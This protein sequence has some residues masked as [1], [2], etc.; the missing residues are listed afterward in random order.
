[1]AAGICFGEYAGAFRNIGNGAAFWGGEMEIS[2]E[3][4][5]NPEAQAAAE[6]APELPVL[7]PFDTQPV[8]A[9]VEMFAQQVRLLLKEAEGI[10]IITDQATA[11]RATELG[12]M[13]KKLSKELVAHK[14]YYEAPHSEYVKKVRNLFKVFLDP[15][16]AI[17]PMLGR[18]LS[19]WRIFQENE[20]RRRIAEQEALARK[21]Q[22]EEEQK[23]RESAEKGAA[24]T[25]VAPAP[26]VVPEVPKTT[27]TTEGSSSQ[28]KEWTFK[29]VDPDKVPN[30][31]R[32]IDEKAIRKA[33]KAGI[34]EI[35][36]VEI[37]QDYI[38]GFRT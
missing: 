30:E 21:I 28:R 32:V 1:M 35:P 20:R 25:P 24:Y 37:F 23:A 18:K 22:K 5:L 11:D 27:R 9:R 26:V 7:A 6:A 4:A 8:S 13:A 14:Q 33:V 12:V 10:Q 34:R 38:T 36:G 29:I 2:F 3:A 31:Y 17:P 16:V 15:L 19:D